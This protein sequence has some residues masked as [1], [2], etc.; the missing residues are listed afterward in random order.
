MSLCCGVDADHPPCLTVC[1]DESNLNPDAS[2]YQGDENQ[3]DDG[4]VFPDQGGDGL[5]L[6]DRPSLLVEDGMLSW[7]GSVLS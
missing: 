7:A 5:H 1:G 4:S 6:V 2:E 3:V